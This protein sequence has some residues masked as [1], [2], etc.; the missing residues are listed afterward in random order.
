MIIT[1]LL[2]VLAAVLATVG[3]IAVAGILKVTALFVNLLIPLPIAVLTLRRGVLAGLAALVV[4]AA[5]LG[6]DGDP[7]G[8]LVYL[9]QFGIA[10]LL[11][12]AL[13]ARGWSWDRAI[14]VTLISML[15]GVVLTLVLQASAQGTTVDGLVTS[16]TSSQIAQVKE[17]Y[18]KTEDLTPLQREELLTALDRTGAFLTRTWVAFIWILGGALLLV[19]VILLSIIPGTRAQISGPAFI[20]WK[21]PETLIWPVIAAGF[22]AFLATGAVQTIA[23]TLLIMLIPIYYLQG[24]AIVTYFFQQRGTPPWLRAIGYM[25][26]FLFNPLPIMVAGFGLFDLWADFRKPRIAPNTK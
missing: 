1:V 16:F 24:L 15:A 13:L 18:A 22:T 7:L 9:A 26:L 25:L 12:P 14:V 3:L 19:E 20:D 10:S 8:P 11:L 5:V 4:S 2:H 6:L 21:G 23:I 17:V